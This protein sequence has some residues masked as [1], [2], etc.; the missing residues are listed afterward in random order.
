[1]IK[2]ISKKEYENLIEEIEMLRNKL[3]DFELAKSKYTKYSK[4]YLDELQKRLELAEMVRRLENETRN[5]ADGIPSN[6]RRI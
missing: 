5:K 1:M 6:T 3:C 2:I 4:L